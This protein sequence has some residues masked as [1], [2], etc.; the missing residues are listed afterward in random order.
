VW[1][2]S[3]LI[4]QVEPLAEA[5]SLCRD[6]ADKEVAQ[7]QQDRE[8]YVNDYNFLLYLRSL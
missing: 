1:D 3:K 7:A 6:G 4:P 2:E 8:D 5:M